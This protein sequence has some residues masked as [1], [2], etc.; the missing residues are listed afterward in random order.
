MASSVYFMWYKNNHMTLST[1]PVSPHF[2]RERRRSLPRTCDK[3]RTLV[4]PDASV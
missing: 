4:A 2:H 3:G 1:V